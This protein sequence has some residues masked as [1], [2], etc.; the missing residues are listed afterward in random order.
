MRKAFRRCAAVAEP[1]SF[2]PEFGW[3]AGTPLLHTLALHHA[4]TLEEV[5]ICGYNGCPV[6]SSLS[7]ETTPLL[8]PLLQCHALRQVVVSF[9]LLTFFEGAY[10]DAQIVQS[11][12]DT[13]SPA[14]TALVVV[15]PRRTP[16]RDRDHP[17]DAAV[18]L[19]PD[20]H[21]AAAARPPAFNRWEVA[22]RTRFSPSALAYRVAADL[23]PF[24][25]P[26]A[27]AREGGVRVRASFC[28]GA[29]EE[30]R[31]ANDIFDL[32]MRIGEE[33][34]VLEFVGPRE[35]GET[36][37]WWAKMEGRQWF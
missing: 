26:R 32:D 12:M 24:L 35:E 17:V 6:L 8:A 15:T 29:R 4:P 11:W 25:S 36:G 27:K 21:P 23:G 37:R 31:V 34:Q 1:F 30:R 19:M 14:S 18:A 13:R 22:L 33:D 2:T 5:K 20:P 28:L 9:W 3:H 10:R 7:P 16:D